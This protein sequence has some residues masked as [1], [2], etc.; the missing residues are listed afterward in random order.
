M[1][2]E[3][4]KEKLD[5]AISECKSVV[6]SI[7]DKNDFHASMKG[8]LVATLEMFDE[9]SVEGE[10]SDEDYIRFTLLVE[11]LTKRVKNGTVKY[12]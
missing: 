3:S 9:A 11:E 12:L 10:I 6:K 4:S 8:L 2:L 1:S 7:K 5:L